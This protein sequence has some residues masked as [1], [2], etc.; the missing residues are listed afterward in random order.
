MALTETLQG[1]SAS[2]DP[3]HEVHA[4]LQALMGAGFP[5][6]PRA[7]VIGDDRLK[8]CGRLSDAV[9]RWREGDG[10]DLV[11]VDDMM[12][13]DNTHLFVVLRRDV[14]RALGIATAPG[15]RALRPLD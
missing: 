4:E 6:F 8:H 13:S 12:A 11:E 10:Y 3:L 2:G 14:E 9:V 7:S 5:D 15:L 1:H